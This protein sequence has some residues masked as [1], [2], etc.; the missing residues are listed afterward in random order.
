MT[1]RRGSAVEKN[2]KEIC[3][4]NLIFTGKNSRG[5]RFCVGLFQKATL[6]RIILYVD[7]YIFVYMYTYMYLATELR[8]YLGW[9]IFQVEILCI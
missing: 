5:F 2:V 9:G 3:K 4:A 1:R 7:I 8:K 6:L